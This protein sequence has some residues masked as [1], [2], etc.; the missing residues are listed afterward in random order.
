MKH[1]PTPAEELRKLDARIAMLCKM[2]ANPAWSQATAEKI[3]RRAD[4]LCIARKML[5]KN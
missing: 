3:M 2:A 1:K 5:A 4:K